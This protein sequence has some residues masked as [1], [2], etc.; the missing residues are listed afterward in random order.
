MTAPKSI[1]ETVQLANGVQMPKF[2]FGTWKMT[3][4]TDTV[5]TMVRENIEMGLRLV[6]TAS[7]YANEGGVGKGFRDS[8]LAREDFFVVSKL[9]NQDQGYDSAIAAVEESLEDLG[10]DYIDLYL[11]HWPVGH[12][13]DHD[14]QQQNLDSWR[15][16][17]KLYR[18]GKLRALGVSNF[19]PHHLEPLMEKAEI[20]ITV[21][22]IEVTLGYHQEEARA[23]NAAHGIATIAY[24]PL[25]GVR[26]ER[27]ELAP[28][29]EKYGKTPHQICLRWIQQLGC[30][31]IPSSYDPAH[32][33]ANTDIFDFEL[34][35]DECAYLATL[36]NTKPFHQ[37]PDTTRIPIEGHMDRHN[38]TKV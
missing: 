4:T 2:G 32:M 21:N 27:P 19:L 30:I 7:L 29:C 9:W 26:A 12:N 25:G 15:A 22:E 8:G 24:A 35:S 20:P 37:H 11:I 23:F 31:P 13:H 14:W 33:R 1:Q 18:D 34:T 10:L 38:R 36:P 5:R 28:L 3:M 16:F 6:D 17:E